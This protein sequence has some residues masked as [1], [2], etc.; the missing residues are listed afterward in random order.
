MININYK[1]SI[2]TSVYNGAATIEQTIQSVL[3]QTYKN[4]EYIVIDGASTDGTQQVIE[5]YKDKIAYYTSE[6]D[7]GI[8]Y[9]MN[10]G[11]EMATGDIVG[12]INSD[13]WYADDIIQSVVDCFKQNDSDLVYGKINKILSDGTEKVCSLVPLENIWY[14]MAMPHPSVFIKNYVYS[15]LGKFDTRYKL[16]A[17]Y[18]LLLRFYTNNIK[19]KC[20]DKVIAHF[21]LDGLSTVKHNDLMKEGY[22]ISMSYI[23]KCPYKDKM[24]PKIK[25]T[26]EWVCFEEMILNKDNLLYELLCRYFNTKIED[27][28]IFGTGAWGERSYKALSKTGIHII[29]FSDNDSAKWGTQFCEIDVLPPNE[30]KN[31][32]AYVLIA[33]KEYGDEIQ[34]QLK[35]MQ[36]DKLVTIKEIKETMEGQ[37]ALC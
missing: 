28:I 8:Y 33:V 37:Y 1:V 14:Q 20:V 15:K 7:D 30:L 11:I 27:I 10:K 19:I 4:I 34:K 29:A 31:R 23:D 18:E 36:N 35:V 2:I 25:E 21:R 9:G 17:D 13:D 32:G 6:K 12:I 22:K 5:K 26:Y 16:A 24:L 3:N